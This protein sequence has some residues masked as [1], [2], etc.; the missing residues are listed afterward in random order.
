MSLYLITVRGCDASTT[1]LKEVN[2]D[3]ELKILQSTAK[4]ITETSTYSCM[5]TMSITE[6]QTK[7]EFYEAVGMLFHWQ[8]LLDFYF[9][10]NEREIILEA[11]WQDDLIEK[12]KNQREYLELLKLKIKPVEDLFSEDYLLIKTNGIEEFI[13]SFK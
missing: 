1:I 6:V 7:E 4:S 10:N 3:D 13:T 8:D 5:P 9:N 2:T 11:S 12:F